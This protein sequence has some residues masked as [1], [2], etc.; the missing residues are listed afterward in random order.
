MKEAELV[1]AL[2]A[3]CDVVGQGQ[4]LPLCR[5][6]LPGATGQERQQCGCGVQRPCMGGSSFSFSIGG[7]F[8]KTAPLYRL[9]SVEPIIAEK[10]G[11]GE[12]VFS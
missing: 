12:A 5:A 9:S 4:A 10:N 11:F 8:I 1:E 6:G 3:S 7:H 2:K